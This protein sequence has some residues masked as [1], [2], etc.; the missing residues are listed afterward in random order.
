MRVTDYIPVQSIMRQGRRCLPLS[1]K[2]LEFA[3]ALKNGSKF[4]PI[5]VERTKRGAYILKDGRNRLAAHKLAGKEIIYATY[6]V[7]EDPRPDKPLVCKPGDTVI[8]QADG[9]SLTEGSYKE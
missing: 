4:P 7:Q 5:H 3:L 6:G 8:P 2:V 9:F 1:P